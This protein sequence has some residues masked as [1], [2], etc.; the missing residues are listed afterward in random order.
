MLYNWKVGVETI[1]HIRKTIKKLIKEKY[2][3][4]QYDI[5]SRREDK[6]LREHE[7]TL[8]KC[9]RVLEKYKKEKY[10][11]TDEI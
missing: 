1:R 7:I 11:D 4:Y 2:K 3:Y 6:E 9:E 10:E 5:E 8:A